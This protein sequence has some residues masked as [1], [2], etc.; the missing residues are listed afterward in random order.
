M[1]NIMNRREFVAL[2]GTAA[3]VEA[4]RVEALTPGQRVA[5]LGGAGAA[6]Y[7]DGQAAPNGFHWEFIT[8]DVDGSRITDD[9][10]L[11]PVVD[12]VAN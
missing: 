8:N 11:Q 5:L 3:L 9:V 6:S 2:A 7:A 4:S 1:A 12:L 10:T